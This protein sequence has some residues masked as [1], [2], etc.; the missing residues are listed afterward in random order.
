MHN[1]S[2]TVTGSQGRFLCCLAVSCVILF[3]G[4]A[5][6]Q[7]TETTR[8][9]QRLADERESLTAELDQNRKTMAMLQP[10]GK[11]AEESPN[12]AIRKLAVEAVALKRQL[13]V[14]TEQEVTLREQHISPATMKTANT[15]NSTATKSSKEP[16]PGNMIE[17]QELPA[18][19]T[20][21]NP[22]AEAENVARLHGLLKSYYLELQES[23]LV[24]PTAEETSRREVAQRDADLLE[25]IPFSAG[26]VRLTGAEGS[27]A[28]AEI[29]QRLMDPGIAESRRDIAPIYL[30][31]TR[32]FDT[33]IVSE[34]RSLRPIG[35][36]HYI[37]RVRLQPGDTTISILSNEWQVR[38]PQQASAR[39]YLITLYRPVDGAPELHVFAIEDLLATD[40]P[41]IPA[42]LPDDLEI[43]KKEG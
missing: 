40:K 4:Q 23:A 27:T 24:L 19:D 43:K 32:L 21:Y 1:P 14:V 31:N 37:A 38:L 15:A 29:T 16:H 25:N 17:S 6:G 28:L 20:E 41:H 3:A 22:Q 2:I 10:N 5:G 11:P 26:K 13:I 36:N 39:D 18:V 35:K 34:S 30:V 12:P 7:S 9:L 8:T 33:L 42:W